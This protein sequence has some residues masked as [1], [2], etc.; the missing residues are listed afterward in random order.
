MSAPR[1]VNC[2]MK[3]PDETTKFCPYCNAMQFGF[4]TPDADPD[5]ELVECPKCH[6]TGFANESRPTVAAVSV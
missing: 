3:L 5:A 4:V 1:C 2:G 6:G